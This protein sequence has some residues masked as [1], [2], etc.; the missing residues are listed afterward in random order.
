MTT[1]RRPDPSPVPPDG[2]AAVVRAGRR[3]RA[4]LGASGGAVAAGLVTVAVLVGAP[5]GTQSL[6]PV[7]PGESPASTPSGSSSAGVTASPSYGTPSDR[8]GSH[9]AHPPGSTPAPNETPIDP[10][11]TGGQTASPDDRPPGVSS[12]HHGPMRTG[13]TVTTRRGVSPSDS[14]NLWSVDGSAQRTPGS[15]FGLYALRIEYCAATADPNPTT[16]QE[17][18]FETEQEADF[19]VV[20][21][22]GHEVWRWSRGQ[23]FATYHH[24]REARNNQCLWWETGWNAIDDAGRKV[25]R[26]TYTVRMYGTSDPNYNNPDVEVDLTVEG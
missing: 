6:E 20:D 26:G 13:T 4:I 17:L 18:T 8:A 21:A 23:S 9:T 16:P 1:F 7:A 5:V 3:R 22:A 12:G 25:A 14:M 11:P 10:A 19:A 24:T 15:P 2:L